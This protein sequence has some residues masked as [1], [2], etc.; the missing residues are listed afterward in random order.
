MKKLLI[1]THN[2]G[3]VSEFREILAPRG[4]D[5]VSAADFNL[6]EPVEDGATFSENA[7]IK[8]RAACAATDLPALSDDSGLCVNALNGDPGIYSAR[9][10]VTENG[11]KDMSLAMNRVHDKLK[12]HQDKSAFFIAVLAFVK[13]NGDEALYEGRCDGNVV[14]PPRGTGG[15]G[16]DP[17][18]SPDGYSATFAE[19]KDGEK[20]ELSH[21]GRAINHFLNA[22]N[23]NIN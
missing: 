21:R 5:V 22:L 9:W 6:A 16:Y 1:A 12:E 20:N 18:F 10:A 19:M 2:S 13:P 3:K 11:E 14:W 8:A 15:H 4:I 23:N 17:I 7:L